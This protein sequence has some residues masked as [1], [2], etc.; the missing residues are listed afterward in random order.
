MSCADQA[1]P[2][3]WV[4]FRDLQA[5]KQH[6]QLAP[7]A[8]TLYYKAAFAPGATSAMSSTAASSGRP[9]A[10]AAAPEVGSSG[11]NGD[12][13]GGVS[14]GRGK[15]RSSSQG[16]AGTAAAAEGDDLDSEDEILQLPRKRIRVLG[17]AGQLLVFLQT[18]P[19]RWGRPHHDSYR[20]CVRPE[21]T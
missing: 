6:Q 14:A 11:S 1:A 17:P 8:A 15:R 5:N 3:A 12:A 13:H 21:N 9:A 16:P 10:A 20:E 7:L 19:E 18:D 2:H 4:Y